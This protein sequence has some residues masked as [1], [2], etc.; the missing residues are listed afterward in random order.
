[1]RRR[2]APWSGCGA[3]TTCPTTRARRT[4]RAWPTARRGPRRPRGRASGLGD[5]GRNRTGR[6]SSVSELCRHAFLAHD[7][8]FHIGLADGP[9]LCSSVVITTRPRWIDIY[10]GLMVADGDRLDMGDKD[11]PV[12]T[13]WGRDGAGRQNVVLVDNDWGDLGMKMAG[14]LKYPDAAREIAA[15][16]A[17][18][19]RR[20]YL[21]S[22]AGACYWREM[23]HAYSSVSFKPAVWVDDEDD[24]AVGKRRSRRGIAWEAFL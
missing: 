18:T 20:R 1:M 16:S 3:T 12:V 9:L 6:R 17:D 15:N 19:F 13:G 23:V 24:G 2:A 8:S 11:H 21:T 5:G 7:S 22:A 4:W 14:L 10:S